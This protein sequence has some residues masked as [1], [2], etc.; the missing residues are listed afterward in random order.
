MVAGNLLITFPLELF[1][2]IIVKRHSSRLLG[3]LS[4]W[5]VVASMGNLLDYVP[6]RTFTDGTDLYQDMYAVER[7]LNWS[8]RTLLLIFGIPVAIVLA[9]FLLKVMPDA[10]RW[11]FPSSPN[12]R[13]AM[14]ILTALF[15]FGFYGMAGLL[16]GGPVSRTLSLLCVGVVMPIAAITGAI[17]IGRKRSDERSTT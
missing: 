14:A 9:F 16:G 13:R 12:G 15:L 3:M 2:I 10:I 17:A 4:Y 6:V 11:L 5:I 1:S 7:G 8:P